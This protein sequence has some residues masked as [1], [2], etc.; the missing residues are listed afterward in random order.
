MMAGSGDHAGLGLTRRPFCIYV[1]GGWSL[2]DYPL[3]C[4]RACERG[5]VRGNPREAERGFVFFFLPFFFSLGSG[6]RSRGL[7]CMCMYVSSQLEGVHP[8]A[9]LHGET[10]HRLKPPDCHR[11][12]VLFQ[13]LF[14][15]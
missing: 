7:A 9:D 2:G 5:V 11:A 1:I 13:Q 4:E 3:A 6:I 10:V 15:R 12:A 14:K 8:P